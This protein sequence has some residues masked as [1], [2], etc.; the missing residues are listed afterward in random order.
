MS[1]LGIHKRWGSK[2]LQRE[3]DIRVIEYANLDPERH[4]AAVAL[5]EREQQRILAYINHTDADDHLGYASSALEF[6][7]R[8]D[9]RKSMAELIGRRADGSFEA[10]FLA[11]W[12]MLLSTLLQAGRWRRIQGLPRNGCLF[13]LQEFTEQYSIAMSLGWVAQADKLHELVFGL[14]PVSSLWYPGYFSA[15][16]EPPREPWGRF[17]LALCSQFYGHPLPT[18]PPHPYESPA[19][20]ALLACWRD[21]DP[22]VL[23]EPL[24]GV[25]DWHTHECMY[26]RSDRPSKNVDFIN[27]VLMGWP[28]EVHTVFRLRER[29]GLALPPLPDHPL[30][31][32][33]MGPYLAPQTV[34][35]DDR[36][37]RVCQRGYGEVSGLRELLGGVIPT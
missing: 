13:Q 18:M 16:A 29:L 9:L 8:R 21:P 32:T 2:F 15:G 26:S 6:V 22:A 37:R 35:L 14:E 20:D 11:A 30:M 31:R 25:C 34:P 10:V 4:S 27:D 12:E 28:V 24:L 17:T 7:G 1:R 3:L 23:V 19:F 5:L 33:P 36:L